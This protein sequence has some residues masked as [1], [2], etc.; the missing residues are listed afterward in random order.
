MAAKD[1]ICKKCG[2]LDR[3][4]KGDFS[5]CRPCHTEAQKRYAARKASGEEV[6]IK[7]PPRRLL[8]EYDFKHN[9]ERAKLVCKNGHPLIGD[10]VRVS[11]QRNDK[12]MR[13]RCRACER[14]AK[15]VTYGLVPEQAPT[16][17][18]AML[19]EQ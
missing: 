3:Y 19:E 4:V 14:N 12:Q 18:T 15:R 17:L 2:M 10:N 6:S 7:K 1:E 13:R 9:F 5:Y 8:H 11:A 16:R